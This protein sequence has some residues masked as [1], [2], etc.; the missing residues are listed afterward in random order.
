MTNCSKEFKDYRLSQKIFLLNSIISDKTISDNG[1]LVYCYLRAIQR[2]DINWYYI[3]VNAMDFYFRQTYDIETR[4]K[5]KYVDG[6]NDLE[7][8]GLIKKI[9]GKKYEFEYDLQPLYF[10]PAKTNKENEMWFSVVY[11]DELSSIMQID[12]A[13]TKTNEKISI[14]KAKIIRY[15]V[16]VVSTFLN[17]QEWSY[18]LSD[19]TRTDGIIGFSSIEV[20]A[21]KSNLSKNTVT[22]YNEILEKE[23]ILYIFRAKDLIV[24]FDG[25]ITG[26]T[27]TYGRYRYKDYVLGKGK[28][29]KAEYGFET[30]KETIKHKTKHT[31]HRKSMGAKYYN[32]VERG[33]KYNEQTIIEIY[34]YAVEF[35][36]AHAEDDY[37]VEKLKDLE[38]FEQ[39]PFIT[40]DCLKKDKKS[41]CKTKSDE[42]IWGEPDPMENDYSVEEILNMSTLNNIY[43][44][45]EIDNRDE[46]YWKVR[47]N[48]RE[49]NF[50]SNKVL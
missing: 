43:E 8:H 20:L 29:H 10:D 39:F 5:K 27:N 49:N 19:G 2:T 33:K 34:K 44:E 18:E 50:F 35:N 23:K 46:F 3:S 7:K 15:F 45:L 12:D 40:E 9:S 42:M 32:L 30:S 6:L 25:S 37:Y 4:D 14:S 28:E 31:Q 11:S 38:F 36:D 24:N 22:I 17:G 21:D 48:D 16:N 47:I 26:I 41:K 1:I 13:V